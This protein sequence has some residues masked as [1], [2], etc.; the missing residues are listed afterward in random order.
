MIIFTHPVYFQEKRVMFV[1]G[2]LASDQW[3]NWL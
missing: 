1:Y 3:Q 2:P